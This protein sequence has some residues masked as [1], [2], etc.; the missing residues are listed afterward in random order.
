VW[1]TCYRFAG[2]RVVVPLVLENK[3]LSSR[4]ERVFPALVEV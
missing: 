3:Q 2:Y 1:D 4:Q